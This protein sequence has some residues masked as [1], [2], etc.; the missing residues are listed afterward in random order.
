MARNAASESAIIP[1]II[2]DGNNDSELLPIRPGLL[3]LPPE[4][5][6][7]IFQYLDHRQVFTKLPL[8]CKALNN[9]V[10]GYSIQLD[11]IIIYVGWS[12]TKLLKLSE[13][14]VGC[15]KVTLTTRERGFSQDRLALMKPEVV[16]LL[17]ALARNVHHFRV[18]T[19]TFMESSAVQL[20]IFQ[21]WVN[22]AIFE[23]EECEELQV[24]QHFMNDWDWKRQSECLSIVEVRLYSSNYFNL[25]DMFRKLPSVE[26]LVLREHQ[27]IGIRQWSL[28]T[29]ND[30][31]NIR[32]VQCHNFLPPLSENVFFNNV[33]R[34]TF[35][36]I[37]PAFFRENFIAEL[38]S[39][40]NLIQL[41]LIFHTYRS[42]RYFDVNRWMYGL[43]HLLVSLS[44]HQ[45]H[46]LQSLR[47]TRSY[48]ADYEYQIENYDQDLMLQLRTLPPRI[49]SI[50]FAV[51]ASDIY[52]KIIRR[53][54]WER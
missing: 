25:P 7:E 11:E 44:G 9:V 53:V 37:G 54:L 39:F 33:Y 35:T 47:I 22:E 14:L 23:N 42:S 38:R 21:Q 40:P 1:K 8:V 4:M 31:Q 19:G 46:H 15:R 43:T 30:L 48:P 36:A 13:R 41:N 3:D 10:V 50:Q 45:L 49:R 6:L 27:R 32:I 20:Q 12:K 34:L 26:K 28:L 51:E 17:K 5:Q 16:K 2:I 29:S 18:Q 52:G 24:L